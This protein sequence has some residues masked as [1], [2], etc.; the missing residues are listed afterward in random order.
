MLLKYSFSDLMDLD[1]P[2]LFSMSYT[3]PNAAIRASDKI[4]AFKNFWVFYD[5]TS[6]SLATRSF[7]MQYSSTEETSNTVIFRLPD[8]FNWV[9]WDK[10]FAYSCSCIGF[11]SSLKQIDRTMTYSDLFQV[12]RKEYDPVETYQHYRRCITKMSEVSNQWIIL[13]AP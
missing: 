11:K 2:V 6:A 12:F 3:I 9:P 5:S 13:E 1:A 10:T 8:T 4:L 7:P